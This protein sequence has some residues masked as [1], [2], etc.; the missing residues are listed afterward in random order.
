MGNFISNLLG[1]NA[2][3]QTPKR[4]L[5]LK[6]KILA[7]KNVYNEREHLLGLGYPAESYPGL[8]SYGNIDLKHRPKYVNPDGTVSS[9]RSMSFGEGGKE[10]LVPT[11][12]ESG[13]SLD[14]DAAVAQYRRTRR[15]LGMFDNPENAT[16]YANRLHEDQ[17]KGYK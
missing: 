7:S 17:A 13:E 16:R 5:T 6:R 9:I 14:D 11:I 3:T 12:S 15:H 4:A 2:P 1:L 10:I 8:L